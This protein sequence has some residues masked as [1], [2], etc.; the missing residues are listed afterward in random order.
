MTKC[1]CP[2]STSGIRG[3]HHST[4]CAIFAP[5]CCC[6]GLGEPCPYEGRP[7]GSWDGAQHLHRCLPAA[8]DL[9][10][11][12]PDG[13]CAGDCWTRESPVASA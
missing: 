2:V 3:M 11:H 10:G 6:H 5:T 4:E 8:L 9:S 13:G 7:E 1:D 12:C